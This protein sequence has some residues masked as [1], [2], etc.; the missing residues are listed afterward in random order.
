[1]NKKPRTGCTHNLE[2]SQKEIF[3]L[4]LKDDY[5]VNNKRGSLGGAGRFT[6]YRKSVQHDLKDHDYCAN[7]KRGSLGV[8]ADI[9]IADSVFRVF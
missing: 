9:H 8:W 3:H 5:C 6:H 4:F 7:K 1:M 2:K